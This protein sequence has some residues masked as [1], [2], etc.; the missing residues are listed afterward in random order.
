MSSSQ[1]AVQ[2]ANSARTFRIFGGIDVSVKVS[3]SETGNAFALFECVIPPGTVVPP[4]SHE[5]EDETFYILEGEFRCQV[6]REVRRVRP[7]DVVF[8]PRGTPHSIEITSATPGRSLLLASPGGL[9]RWLAE[10]SEVD[11]NQSGII[12]VLHVSGRHGIELL[13][14]AAA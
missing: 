5:R 1:T 4:H 2:P 10:L 8:I 6:G 9:E 14:Q 12:E 11:R 13:P 7:G 3:S